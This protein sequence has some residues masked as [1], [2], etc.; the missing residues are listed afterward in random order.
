L[1]KLFEKYG[2]ITSAIV[3]R[4][5]RGQSKGFG[6]VCFAHTGNAV[7]AIK[8]LKENEMS[9]P[10]LPPLYVNFAMKKEER[11][12]MTQKDRYSFP[13]GE[14]AKFMVSCFDPEIVKKF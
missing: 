4:D 1:K 12:Q 13:M 11:S 14:T 8:D 9:F 7:E 3:S 6:F 5:D 10:G 2:D